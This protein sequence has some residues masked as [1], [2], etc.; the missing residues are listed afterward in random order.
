MPGSYLRAGSLP[1]MIAYHIDP[2]TQT[3]T[4]IKV[5]TSSRQVM[6]DVMKAKIESIADLRHFLRGWP[7]NGDALVI[8]RDG[9]LMGGSFRIG[10]SD[11]FCGHALIIAGDESCAIGTSI[12]DYRKDIMFTAGDATSL[13]TAVDDRTTATILAALRFYQARGVGDATVQDIATNGGSLAALDAAEI[14]EL[15]GQLNQS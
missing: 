4:E 8:D 1:L 12:A 2:T 14:D 3:L 13:L 9:P 6:A 7:P 5:D 15:C 11:E 10:N